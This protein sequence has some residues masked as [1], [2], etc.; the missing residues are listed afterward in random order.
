MSELEVIRRLISESITTWNVMTAVERYNFTRI[1]YLV[2]FF[3]VIF[4]VFLLW[5]FEIK[6]TVKNILKIIVMSMY[7]YVSTMWF[8]YCEYLSVGNVKYFPIFLLLE[9]NCIRKMMYIVRKE[10][11]QKM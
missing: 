1:T 2:N 4:F 8:L 5:G 6:I 3:Y 9:I 7:I 10:S 11:R